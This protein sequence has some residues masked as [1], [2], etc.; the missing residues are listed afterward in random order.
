MFFIKV[1]I[2]AFFSLLTGLLWLL[3]LALAAYVIKKSGGHSEWLDEI[4]Y[5]F[6]G[7]ASLIAFAITFLWLSYFSKYSN[8]GANFRA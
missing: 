1:F 3:L 8:K 5:L 2:S 7:L 4:K 6:I